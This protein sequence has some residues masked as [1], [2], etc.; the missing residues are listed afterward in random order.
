MTLLID[1]RHYGHALRTMRTSLHMSRGDAAR[2]LG[3]DARDF[4]AYERGKKCIP[5][6]VLNKIMHHAFVGLCTR[7]ALNHQKRRIEL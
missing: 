5:D 1:A 6:D 7:Y 4:M 2:V 3:I